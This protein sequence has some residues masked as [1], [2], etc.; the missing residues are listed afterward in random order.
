MVFAIFFGSAADRGTET[1]EGERM[2]GHVDLGN[3]LDA[4][5]EGVTLEVAE[6]VLAVR[7]VAGCQA[8]EK[9][10]FE[11]ESGLSLVPIIV[12]EVG[13]AIVVEVEVKLV[14]LVV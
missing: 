5:A 1:C 7:A 10:A 3:N 11:T 4:A 14:E 2:G 8:G 12:L 13:E 9:F 6:I